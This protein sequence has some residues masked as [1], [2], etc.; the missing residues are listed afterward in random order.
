MYRKLLSLFFVLFSGLAF[1]ACGK[2]ETWITQEQHQAALARHNQQQAELEEE[3]A[4]APAKAVFTLAGG[5]F[6]GVAFHQDADAKGITYKKAVQNITFV[7]EG[8]QWKLAEGSDSVFRV[9]SSNEYRY[10]YG[11]WI[12]Y[13]DKAG[14]DI[15]SKIAEDGESKAHQH[16][17]QASNVVPTFDGAA[18]AGDNVTDSLFEYTYMDTNPT[19]GVLTQTTVD[20]KVIPPATL[21]GSRVVGRKGDDLLFA[22]ENPIG[23]KGFF[24]FKRDRKRFDLTISLYHFDGDAK[25]LGGSPSGYVAPRAGQRN[26]AHLEAQVKVPVIVYASREESGLWDSEEDKSF[27]QLHPEE[28]RLVTSTARAY[29]ISILQALQEWFAQSYGEV[30]AESGH[31]W[32]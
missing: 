6:H 11:L 16:F 3:S 14:K 22:P 1:V 29:G 28:Q 30:D 8:K 2:D 9:L 27:D 13:Y 18:Q 31:L 17:F 4:H 5:H 20:G 7:R 10:P 19:N 12:K 21:R 24:Q 23:V 32:F 15:T 25:F 26:L